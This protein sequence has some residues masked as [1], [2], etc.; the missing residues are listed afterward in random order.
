MLSSVYIQHVFWSLGM[1]V[2]ASNNSDLLYASSQHWG[3]IKPYYSSPSPVL[4]TLRRCSRQSPKIKFSVNYCTAWR[5]SNVWKSPSEFPAAPH[6]PF[7]SLADGLLVDFVIL[8]FLKLIINDIFLGN[9][10]KCQM[11]IYR[12]EDDSI[13]PAKIIRLQNFIIACVLYCNSRLL[14]HNS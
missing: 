3:W 7:L 6:L 10:R 2:K 11:T 5:L 4:N 8:H 13:I 14:R 1:A 12:I 9:K